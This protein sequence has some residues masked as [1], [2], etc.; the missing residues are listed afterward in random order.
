M[1]KKAFDLFVRVE[2]PILGRWSL[3]SCS[4]ISTSI[5]S[6]YQNRDHCGDV[7]CKTPKKASEYKDIDAPIAYG[8]DYDHR[9]TTLGSDHEGL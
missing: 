9:K 5:N 6:V 8:S 3:K 4:E 1:F 7:I 2:K